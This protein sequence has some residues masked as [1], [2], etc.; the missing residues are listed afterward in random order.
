[1]APFSSLVW[2][3]II[4]STLSVQWNLVWNTVFKKKKKTHFCYFV[5]KCRR[6]CKSES[7]CIGSSFDI[8]LFLWVWLFSGTHYLCP[9][10]GS[11]QS[12]QHCLRLSGLGPLHP[13]LAES[14]SKAFARSFWNT[15][16]IL[17]G[18]GKC[19]DF[20][21][22]CYWTIRDKILSSFGLWLPFAGWGEAAPIS[23]TAP[24]SLEMHFFLFNS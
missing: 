23:Q 22:S 2:N 14:V 4:C 3:V 19:A 12:R 11:N 24:I 5:W 9:L 13:W 10:A 16:K 20:R 17:S 21:S 15:G 7:N 6:N 18:S 8:L 1:M